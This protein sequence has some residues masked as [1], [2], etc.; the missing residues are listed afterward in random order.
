MEISNGKDICEIYLC[1]KHKSSETKHIMLFIKKYRPTYKLKF[2][3]TGWIIYFLL[4][5]ELQNRNHLCYK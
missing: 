1:F 2:L 3:I 5:M 4:K